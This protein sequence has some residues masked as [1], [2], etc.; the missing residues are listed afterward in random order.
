MTGVEKLHAVGDLLT[1]TEPL[2]HLSL[3]FPDLSRLE[4]CVD[5]LVADSVRVT[6]CA[7]TLHCAAFGAMSFVAAT[8]YSCQQADAL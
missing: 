2:L 7:G 4:S 1:L 8:Q 3:T 5:G 6:G